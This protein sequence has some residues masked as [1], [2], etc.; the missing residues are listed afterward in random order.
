MG[1]EGELSG[2]KETINDVRRDAGYPEAPSQG[3]VVEMMEEVMRKVDNCH[4]AA[5]LH[6]EKIRSALLPEEALSNDNSARPMPVMSPLAQDLQ[7]LID[8]LDLLHLRILSMT[9]RVDL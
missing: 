7:R 5:H 3:R 4:K 6:E 1:Y 2:L 9:D 8:G